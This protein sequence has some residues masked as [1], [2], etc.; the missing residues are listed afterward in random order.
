M[1]STRALANIEKKGGES[2][3]QMRIRNMVRTDRARQLQR[4][5]E[6][7]K[8]QR[9]A[10]IED[11]ARRMEEV[12]KQQKSLVLRRERSIHELFLKEQKQAMLMAAAPT[13]S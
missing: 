6:F 13:A 11:K 7:E 4:Q 10:I 5:N 9:A 3:V 8:T 2:A 12:A 1:R